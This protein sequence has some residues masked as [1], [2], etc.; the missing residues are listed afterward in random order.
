MAPQSRPSTAARASTRTP[1]GNAATSGTGLRLACRPDDLA[2]ERVEPI[3]HR[4][5]VADAEVEAGPHEYVRA[6]IGRCGLGAGEVLLVL[7]QPAR[8]QVAVVAKVV[9]EQVGR[10]VGAEH[11]GEQHRKA[12]QLLAWGLRD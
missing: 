9:G 1:T 2:G 11:H 12:D 10:D 3:E 7:G 5:L 4:A 6:V 8:V